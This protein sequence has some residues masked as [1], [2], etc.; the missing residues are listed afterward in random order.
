MVTFFGSSEHGLDDK[1]RLVLPGRILDE[2]PKTKWRF[3][4]TA[5]LDKCLLLHDDDGFR[6]IAD[7]IAG[8][9]PGSRAH[10]A[11]VRRFLG[12]SEV[13]EPDGNRRIRIPD[14]L[15]KYAGLAASQPVVLL[16]TGRVIEIWSPSMLDTALAE[17]TPD[18]ET[19]FATLVGPAK[20]STPG[21]PL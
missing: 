8:S 20:P 11:L 21:N 13:V 1:G 19:L 6:E 15:L 14:P 4:L 9:V 10:R 18:E 2:V 7:R 16:G 17:A 12:H 5:G 3:H